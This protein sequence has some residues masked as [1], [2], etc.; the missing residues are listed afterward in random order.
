LLGVVL[1]LGLAVSGPAT[2]A[3]IGP[4]AG[5][6]AAINGLQPG[7]ELLL[8]PGSYQAGCVIRRGGLAGSPIVIRAQDPG[9]R[10]RLTHAGPAVNML[11]IRASDVVVRGLD[12]GP[13]GS[14]EDGI[15]IIVGNRITV[16]DCH[17]VRMNGIAI[18][19][20]HTS[21]D[22]LTV[23]RNVIR[24]AGATGMYFGCHDGATCVISGLRVERNYIHG[25]TAPY[26]QIGYG[27][28]VKL[29]SSG[30]IV[31]N[32]I[33][34]TKG[35][36]IMVYG[37]RDLATTSVVERNFVSGSRTSSGIVLGGGPA[38]VRNNVSI[39]NFESGIGLENYRHRGLLRG[40]V[41]AHNTVYGN[42]QAGISAP[43]G[44]RVET[45]LVNN[46]VHA[47]RGTP[48][49]PAP[50]PGLSVA[51]NVNCS[52]APCF[53]NPELLDFS[54]FAGSLLLGPG[55]ENGPATI[56]RDDFFG[57]RRRF[58]PAVGA[59]ERPGNPIQ[60]RIKQE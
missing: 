33:V 15:R 59:I 18:V 43:D 46:A 29:N 7:E 48:G 24:E 53:G 14:D 37:A 21:V 20:N 3:E 23:R 54:P 50:R 44:G 30:V 45:V 41:V 52:L 8:R 39:G 47:R 42:T 57:A 38:V 13:T 60:L 6:C 49:L 17:F 1:A 58:P 5:L 12:F 9:H 22:G 31:D 35:P 11:E 10:P 2:A 56:P 19:A 4:E 16:E 26:P 40:I 27:L 55:V 36:G 51:G 34:E 25:V 32:V 28:E